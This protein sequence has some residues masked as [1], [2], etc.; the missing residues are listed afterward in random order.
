MNMYILFCLILLLFKEI[1]AENLDYLNRKTSDY[2]LPDTL[3]PIIYEV[4]LTL[5]SDSDQIYG[6]VRIKT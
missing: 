5:N 3:N 4:K 1:I 2:R 6:Y